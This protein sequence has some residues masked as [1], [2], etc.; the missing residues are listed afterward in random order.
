MKLE[1]QGL[2]AAICEEATAWLKSWL[3][4][5]YHER[6]GDY[7]LDLKFRSAYQAAAFDAGW[8]M[9]SWGPELGGHNVG[10]E[11]EVWIKLHFARLNAP[12]LPNIQGPG[13][14]APALLE[15]GTE[16]Q[17]APVA[18]VVRGDT[19]WCLGMSEPQAGSDLA[20]LRTTAQPNDDGFVLNGQKVWTSHARDSTHC[21][22]FAR[23]DKLETRHRGITAFIMPMNTPGVSVRA[24][25]KIGAGD[26]EFCEVFL[27][28]VQLPQSA[29]LG[30]L[31]GGWKV[32]MDSLAFER[33][34]IWIM[35]LVEIERA[36]ELTEVSLTQHPNAAISIELERMRA[37]A[38]SIWLTGLRGLGHRLTERPNAETP[39]LKLFSTEAA[40]RAFDLAARATGEEAALIGAGSPFDGEIVMGEIEGLGATIYGGTSEVQRNI[41]GEKILG[42][43]R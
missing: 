36:L 6:I 31:N 39:I 23:T 28:E 22:L 10:E 26:E 43:P 41:I 35:N 2:D 37:D 14:L 12:K 38:D 11:A 32:A 25:E 30:P 1:P 40:Q 29:M 34:M 17:Q 33:D 16:E 19:W 21:V 15:F 42:L 18:S 3:P 13:V 8:L 7:R 20:S 27:D 5:D 4:A 24:I 9:P